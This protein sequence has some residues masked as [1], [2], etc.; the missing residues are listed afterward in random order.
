MVCN[1]AKCYLGEIEEDEMCEASGMC[2]SKWKYVQSC[3]GEVWRIESKTGFD[4]T[5]ILKGILNK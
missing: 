5:K 2:G 1:F 4:E 3:G